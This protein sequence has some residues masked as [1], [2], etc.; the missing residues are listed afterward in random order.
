[1]KKLTMQLV[2]AF[3]LGGFNTA[4]AEDAFIQAYDNGWIETDYYPNAKTVIV[5]DFQFSSVRDQARLFGVSHTNETEVTCSFYLNG[6][7]NYAWGLQDG[8]GDWI[9]TGIK[10]DFLRRKVRLD[11]PAQKVSLYD[12]NYA[13][14][15]GE[16][17]FTLSKEQTSANR[18]TNTSSTPLHL[19]TSKRNGILHYNYANYKAGAKIYSLKIYEDGELVRDYEPRL[20][21]G[22][23]G[24]KE[25]VSGKFCTSAGTPFFYGGD[26]VEDA[27]IEA[28]GNGWIETDYYPNP[29]T[30][31]VADFKFNQVV[32]QARVFGTSHTAADDMTCSFY[33][34]GTQWFAWGFRNG[35]GNWTQ[36]NTRADTR[37]HQVCF[38]SPNQTITLASYD[39]NA[40]NAENQ[41][42]NVYENTYNWQ[43]T[44]TAKTPLHLFTSKRNGVLHYNNADYKAK[45]R[46]YSVKVYEDDVLVRD[47]EPFVQG[48]VAGMKEMLSG[49]FYPSAGEPFGCGGPLEIPDE[50]AYI[51]AEGLQWIN[52]DYY[53]SPRTKITADFQFTAITPQARIFG[54]YDSNHLSIAPYIN[55]GRG[56]GLIY[57][58]GAPGGYP[59][60]SSGAMDTKRHTLTLNGREDNYVYLTPATGGAITNQISTATI[61]LPTLTASSPLILG[62]EIGRGKKMHTINPNDTIDTR[63]YI[64]FYGVKIWDWND[65]A[66]EF[67]LVRDYVPQVRNGVPGLRDRVTGRFNASEAESGVPFLCGGAIERVVE[68]DPYIEATGNQWIETDYY[69]NPKTRIN[70]DFQFTQPAAQARV[71]GTSHTDANDVTCSFYVNGGLQYAWGCQNSASTWTGTGIAAD[72][73][74]RQTCF[75]IPEKQFRL[76]DSDGARQYSCSTYT[77]TNTAQ[78]ALHLLTSKRNGILHYNN[79][80]YKAKARLYGVKIYEDN[81]LVRD[82]EPQVRDGMAGMAELKSDAFYPSAGDAFLSGEAACPLTDA[83]TANF[84]NYPLTMNNGTLDLQGRPLTLASIGGSGTVANGSLTVIDK[85][86]FDAATA[87]DPDKVLEFA[88]SVT[89]PPVIEISDPGNLAEN[90][91]ASVLCTFAEPQA[92]VPAFTAPSS[93]KLQLSADGMTLHLMNTRGTLMIL[94]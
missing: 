28:N 89:L 68:A 44:N 32:A 16:D 5:A 51:E 3:C 46:I 7:V 77:V 18:I 15:E 62:S 66:G 13:A 54:V 45:C 2:A 74:R 78:T 73:I 9:A 85:I 88:A 22:V 87:Q 6:S 53:A 91:P 52:T 94:R 41:F 19:F 84:A 56:L 93:W 1:M 57:A 72:T 82:Y 63:A 24:L 65:A 67:T 64:K 11:N 83:N 10:G 25:L 81:A 29:Q 55:V 58:D 35:E 21:N 31:I 75:D 12:Y 86:V 79:A 49:V 92:S 69:P 8:A 43:I 26:L 50:A 70:A 14:A 38:D 80:G 90:L 61:P 47:F 59:S 76:Y 4:Q 37:R 48:A 60:I 23:A 17:P 20:Q 36:T 39:D 71:F 42:T 34:N 40:V 30:K 27:F 33:A